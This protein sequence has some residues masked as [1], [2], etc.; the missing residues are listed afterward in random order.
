MVKNHSGVS[1]HLTRKKQ[2]GHMALNHLP[3]FRGVIVLKL[4]KV[5]FYY[6]EAMKSRCG[7]KKAI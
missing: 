4:Y 2:E 3:E 5:C 6:V 1:I 7:F